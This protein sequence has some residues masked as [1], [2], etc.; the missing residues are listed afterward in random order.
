MRYWEGR[1][2]KP[3]YSR[4][5]IIKQV[6][7]FSVKIQYRGRRE[8][9]TLGTANKA[10]AAEKA[11][12]IYLALQLGGWEEALEQFKPG[13]AQD[14]ENLTVGEFLEKVKSVT[15]LAPRTFANYSM[16]FRKMVARIAGIPTDHKR[17]DKKN[18]GRER[19]IDAIEAIPLDRITPQKIE[20]WKRE[21][22]APYIGDPLK[23]RK[24]KN[25]CNSIIGNAGS[26]FSERKVLRHLAPEY[27]IENPF[28]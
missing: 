23:E 18:G 25:T 27:V 21:F 3:T 22:V 6:A 4:D 14:G 5:G 2:F 1:I 11:K 28:K 16:V 19:W 10:N 17:F 8:T 13:A 20:K 12:R 7:E 24:A 15:S 9:F 26:L